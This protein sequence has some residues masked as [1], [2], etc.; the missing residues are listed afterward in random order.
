[1][2]RPGSIRTK[3]ILAVCGAILIAQ[4]AVAAVSVWQEASLYAQSKQETMTS[5]A[6]AIAAAVAHSAARGDEQGAFRALRAIGGIPGASYVRV[7]DRNGRT[8]A[9]TGQ[10]EQLET[11]VISL[12]RGRPVD[13]LKLIGSRTLEV[14]APVVESGE[15]VGRLV[16]IGDISDLGD[17]L[18][19]ALK[20]TALG[21]LG[22][23]LLAVLIALR[24]LGPMT[25]PLVDLAT[26]MSRVRQEHDYTAALTSTRSDEIGVLIRGFD[27][28]IT[29]I[30]HRTE[31]LAKHRDKLEQDVADRTADYRRAMETAEDANKAKSDFLATMSHE[32]RTPMNGVMV[33]AELLAASDLPP[34]ARKNA[35]VI[36]R[37]GQTLLAIINDILDL[38][39]IEAGKLEVETMPVDPVEAAEDV[40][41]LFGDRAQSKNLDFADIIRLPPGARVEADPVRLNQVLSN[42]VNNALKFTEKGG[43]T[44]EIEQDSA[45]PSRVSFAV[46]DTGI[47]IAED[48]LDGIFGAFTQADQST[49]R[50]FGG[51]GLG[52][53]IARKL[54]AAMGGDLAVSSS[55]GA[56]ARFYFSL[57]ISATTQAAMRPRLPMDAPPARAVLC[58]QGAGTAA[59]IALPLREAGFVVSYC[60][61]EELA[62]CARGARLVFADLAAL[63]GAPR[64][65]VAENGVLVALAG[66]GE[67]PDRLLADRRADHV[68]QRPLLRGDTDAIVAA[69]V[70]GREIAVAVVEKKTVDLPRFPNARVLVVDDGAV[71]REVA[72]EALRRLG[73]EADMANDGQ[74]AVERIEGKTYDLVLMDGS[75]PV[76]DGYAATRAIR[77]REAETG[78]ARLKVVALT[79]HVVGAGAEAWREAGMDGV[80]HK[81]FTLAAMAECLATHISGATS[82]ANAPTDDDSTAEPSTLALD[83]KVLEGL[84]EM[85]GGDNAAVARIVGLYRSHAPKSVDAIEA[86]FAAQDREALASA[87][88]ALKSMSANIGATAV[89][90]AT[91]AIERACR[92]DMRLPEEAMVAAVRPLVEAA[93]EAAATLAEQPPARAVA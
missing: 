62:D 16:L 93:C 89:A 27:A 78:R 77:A 15:T 75:M 12:E 38:S 36:V 53:A 59:H 45:D 3:F 84:R 18:L 42:L 11:D 61:L 8:L 32:I 90:A 70:E 88:H 40:M 68:L 71:N 64:L 37:S 49:T 19:S 47:G 1:M 72:G 4:L 79:A 7:E 76:M 23:L 13:Q 2:G 44:V 43:V 82:G 9:E 14:A 10:A 81:P 41:R 55:T 34:R 5:T 26:V 22:A 39:K 21:G 50:K 28:M 35:D 56:G 54:V 87:A 57:P 86:A 6:Q 29:E 73:I 52:L 67:T 65:G 60:A 24:M 66:L 17:R 51:T 83:V 30:R 69:V 25:R 46:V 48:K 80:L 33:M 31:D 85:S 58:V 20:L 92:L 91:V 74:E 63:A